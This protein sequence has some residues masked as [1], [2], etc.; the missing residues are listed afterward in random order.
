[1]GATR[2]KTWVQGN[3]SVSS[4]FTFF[5]VSI[6]ALSG[7]FN[8]I[9][10]LKTRPASGLFGQLMFRVPA[11]PPSVRSGDDVEQRDGGLGKIPS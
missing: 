1:M 10:L 11:R 8:S 4:A 7:F 2:W 3:K 6:F 5:A 9:L